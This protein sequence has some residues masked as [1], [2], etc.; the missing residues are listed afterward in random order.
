MY[1]MYN[2]IQTHAYPYIYSPYFCVDVLRKYGREHCRTR[3]KIKVKVEGVLI[4]GN[5]DEKINYSSNIYMYSVIFFKKRNPS[6]KKYQGYEFSY[7]T[8]M[9]YYIFV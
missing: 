6:L 7:I 2:Q 3:S 5:F 8:I 1:Y 9:L 4:K